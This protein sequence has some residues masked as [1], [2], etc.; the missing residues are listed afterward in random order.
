M[1]HEDEFCKKNVYS[2]RHIQAVGSQVLERLEGLKFER[3]DFRL[4]GMFLAGIPATMQL[5]A[6]VL[7]LGSE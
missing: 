6:S 1:F 2:R 5:F 7:D 3:P 4:L